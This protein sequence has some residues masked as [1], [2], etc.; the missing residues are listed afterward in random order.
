VRDGLLGYFIISPQG[1]SLGS[2]GSDNTGSINLL[3]QEPEF[4]EQMRSH[5]AA[6]GL[7]MTSDV[8]LQND[9][10]RSTANR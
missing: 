9:A 3:W 10:P 5:G 7:L 8:Q 4:I 6:L 1:T 2:L